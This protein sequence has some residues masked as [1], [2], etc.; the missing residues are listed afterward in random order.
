MV[1]EAL[2]R[3]SFGPILLLV[4]LIAIAPVPS[5]IPGVPVVMWALV[6]LITVQLLLKRDHLWLPGFIARRSLGSQKIEKGL[7]WIRPVSRA[8]DY[9]TKGRL[10]KWMDR[11]V[12]TAVAF[13]CFLV[14]LA[15]PVMEFIPFS[16]NLAGITLLIFGLA[17]TVHD[18]LFML[19][20]FVFAGSVLLL[21]IVYF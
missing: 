17:L 20:G 7:S 16:I 14:G 10:E 2:G 19:L 5:G 8:A 13:I 18:G 12:I 1:V 21:G 15:M 3:R 11:R 6:I 9:L 4:G